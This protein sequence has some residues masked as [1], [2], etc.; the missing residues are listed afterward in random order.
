MGRHHCCLASMAGHPCH[1][2]ERASHRVSHSSQWKPSLP[3]LVRSLKDQ[4]QPFITIMKGS[5]APD[6][7]LIY[8]YVNPQDLWCP[9][10]ETPSRSH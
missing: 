5:G 7:I 4:I 8:G 10:E 2:G 6:D 1:G 9:T 3:Q